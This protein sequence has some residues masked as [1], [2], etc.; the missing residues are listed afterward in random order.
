LYTFFLP[1][2]SPGGRIFFFELYTFF[3]PGLSLFTYAVPRRSHP[4]RFTTVHNFVGSD[5]ASAS[6]ETF[7]HKFFF[8]KNHFFLLFRPVKHDPFRFRIVPAKKKIRSLGFA[9][10]PPCPRRSHGVPKAPWARVNLGNTVGTP[11]EREHGNVLGAETP[12]ENFRRID[13]ADSVRA[14]AQIEEQLSL[15]VFEI[16]LFKD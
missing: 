16:N 9:S 6:N 2:L 11:C 12:W 8:E 7:C 13:P 5:K 1:G 3:L 14:I 15:E 10:F 4:G